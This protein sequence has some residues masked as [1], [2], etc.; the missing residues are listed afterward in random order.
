MCS[1][2]PVSSSFL[3]ILAAQF[4][5][6]S[7]SSESHLQTSFSLRA[8]IL[9]PFPLNTR[10]KFDQFMDNFYS[11]GSGLFRPRGRQ[12]SSF[13]HNRR[14]VPGNFRSGDRRTANFF[15]SVGVG[16]ACS[17]LFQ[18][19]GHR[20]I[21]SFSHSVGGPQLIPGPR[22]PR[23]PTNSNF[24]KFKRGLRIFAKSPFDSLLPLNRFVLHPSQV[25]APKISSS[26]R[27]LSSRNASL[28]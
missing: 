23:T 3:N 21:T 14:A 8:I 18:P 22:Q 9:Q 25:T 24:L 6:M 15:Y 1:H 5:Q 16:L 10:L 13:S 27:R 7:C 20:R 17:R 19:R 28:R 26:T 2:K 4:F 12:F 11:S